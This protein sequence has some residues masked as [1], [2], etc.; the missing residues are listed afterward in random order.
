MAAMMRTVYYHLQAGPTCSKILTPI[1]SFGKPFQDGVFLGSLGMCHF[2][3]IP[4]LV[5]PSTIIA[6]EI[7]LDELHQAFRRLDLPTPLMAERN[8]GRIIGIIFDMELDL[9]P[10]WS[11]KAN[12]QELRPD[13]TPMRKKASPGI[14]A[15]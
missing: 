5:C 1:D 7:L 9:Y 10:I 8:L 3:N 13:P 12:W 6:P 15:N 2:W 11:M 14:G 4:A